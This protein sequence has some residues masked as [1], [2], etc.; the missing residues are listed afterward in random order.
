MMLYELGERP[1]NPELFQGNI[2]IQ[3]QKLYEWFQG[4]QNVLCITG[5]GMSTDSGIP[6][7]RGHN[8]SYYKNH[9]PTLHHE[10]IQKEQTRKRYWARSMIGW[11]EFAD[12]APNE[13]HVALAT[14]ERFQKIGVTFD[15]CVTF[16]NNGKDDDSA[17][18]HPDY[19]SSND[20]DYAFT[21]GSRRISIITQNVD[22]LHSKAGNK[23]VLDL[24]GRNDIV[25]CQTCASQYCRHEFHETLKERNGIFL[26]RI[27]VN[28]TTT[29]N[30]ATTIYPT[31]TT[32]IGTNQNL[33]PDGDAELSPSESFHDFQ[34]LNCTKCKDH[35]GILKPDV[36]FFGDSVPRHRVNECYAAVNACDGLLVIGSS[37]A[38]HSA[39]RFVNHATLHNVP[40]AVLN[41]GKTRAET[42]GI[43]ITKI[44]API[45]PTLMELLN[46]FGIYVKVVETSV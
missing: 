41:M 37:L 9:S 8:G 23:F 26:E 17:K 30:S 21:S 1:P 38:V 27:T 46:L 14:L 24:H 18:H 42:S 19:K 3:A 43:N 20:V 32:A 45:G 36:V 13:G 7:Y 31:N 22:R 10:F 28:S 40:I 4:K 6:D 34:V 44:D 29:A 2:Q 33:R 15:D 12:A 11:K 5:A 16:Y 35:N 39:Y 25:K